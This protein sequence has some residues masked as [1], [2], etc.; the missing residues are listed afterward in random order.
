MLETFTQQKIITVCQP[1]LHLSR[2]KKYDIE[3]SERL[4]VPP[5][6][7]VTR[8]C[9]PFLWFLQLL[10]P[11]STRRREL[12]LNS[13]CL[14]FFQHCRSGFLAMAITTSLK[15]TED[16]A[17]HCK[18]FLGCE[19]RMTSHAENPSFTWTDVETST[20]QNNN[21]PLQASLNNVTSYNLVH[22]MRRV[23]NP[24]TLLLLHHFLRISDR[25]QHLLLCESAQKKKHQL[26]SNGA[27]KALLRLR[28]RRG[29]K[30]VRKKK[31]ASQCALFRTVPLV[32]DGHFR[33]AFR[34]TVSLVSNNKR[35]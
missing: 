4:L 27:K 24:S 13:A 26:L 17:A 6:M 18:K 3:S 16:D 5:T 28:Q 1:A 25:H 34:T 8:C 23:L 19:T 29:A 35:L 11:T 12:R 2:R 10:F 31:C 32:P 20:L 21:L 33:P 9:A 14:A 15:T 22:D 30:C 7:I